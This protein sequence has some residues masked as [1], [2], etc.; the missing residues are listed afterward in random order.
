LRVPLIVRDPT[1]RNRGAVVE[2]PISVASLMP[3]ILELAGFDP[4][5]FG[6]HS[7]SLAGAIR[8][9]SKLSPGVVYAEVDYRPTRRELPIKRT[10]MKAVVVD[11]FKLVRD[12]LR[13]EFALYDLA[14]DPEERVNLAAARPELVSRL[15]RVLAE[16]A[17]ALRAGARPGGT[18]SLSAQET[19][20]LRELGYLEGPD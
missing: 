5:P 10:E 1:G 12:E 14:A 19:E 20:Q 13:G 6:F 8:G 17:T 2:Q 4:T 15:A 9:E 11:H 16:R 7:P 18:R 3:T